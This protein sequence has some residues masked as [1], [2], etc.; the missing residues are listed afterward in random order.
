M[1]AVFVGG[2]AHRVVGIL[3]GALAGSDVLRGGEV[4]LH[5]LDAS[6]AELVARTV[7]QTPEYA[8]AD[9][10][11]TWG[12]SLPEALEGADAVSVILMAGSRL[13]FELG[14][15]ASLRQGFLTSDNV[16]PSGAFL[17]IKGGR[18]L[19]GL[20]REMERRCPDAWLF[21]F[22]NPVAVFSAMLNHHTR[23]R[24][25]G[26]CAGYLNHFWD[27]PRLM[28]WDEQDFGF[29]V[30]V[31]G[32]NHCSFILKGSYRG[33]DLFAV[34]DRTLTDNWKPVRLK[35]HWDPVTRRN[36]GLGLRKMWEFYRNLGVLVFSTEF[37][38]MWH[39]FYDEALAER[40][41]AG[42]LTTPTQIRADCRGADAARRRADAALRRLI[43]EP[44][45]ARF[46]ATEAHG[47]YALIRQDHDIIARLL[48]GVGGREPI[49]VVASRPTEG[50]L[51]GFKPRTVA[52]YSLV[53][54]AGELKPRGTYTIPDSVH[55][56]MSALAT[57]QTLLGDAIA[58]ED[59]R[60]LAQALLAY[61]VR[62]NSKAQKTLYRDLLK[63]NAAEI[64]PDL[65]RAAEW[66]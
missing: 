50:A 65:Q 29:D 60:L 11:I 45:K 34:M 51:A 7:M 59:P 61:P 42:F 15:R 8:G 64:P 24:S 17:A 46:W 4:H 28:G 23:I 5:D 9:C 33:E 32:I 31:A 19:L 1:K 48:Q 38:G 56:L 55:G 52:E 30:E 21:D 57:H 14:N 20:A 63:I 54:C 43:G 39:L 13:T 62:P 36:I 22:A 35:R 40:R 41:S 16:S 58:T 44:H 49:T 66:L 53:M 27:L 37:D 47:Q 18:T 25:L 12:D 26:V 10:R 3:R 2:G 6:R